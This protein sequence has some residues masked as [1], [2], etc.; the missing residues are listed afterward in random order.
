MN[1][2]AVSPLIA[3]VLLIAFA[4][5]LGAVVMNWSVKYA[6]A[7]HGCDDMNIRFEELGNNP[8]VCFNAQQQTVI[9]TINNIGQSIDGVK[10]TV[11]GTQSSQEIDSSISVNSNSIQKISLPYDAGVHG[12]PQKIVVRPSVIELG[13]SK[14]CQEKSVE[15]EHIPSC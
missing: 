11:I 9:F 4:V 12:S 3:T 5:A 2:K 7:T 13:N 14:V 10:A 15:T 8:D 1:K 6:P